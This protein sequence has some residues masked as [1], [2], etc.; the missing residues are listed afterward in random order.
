MFDDARSK[1]VVLV[2]HC[3]LNQNARSDGYAFFPGVM[4]EAA[5]VLSESGAG[6]LQMPCPELL[7]LGLKREQH[8]APEVGIRDALGTEEGQ[9]CCR[10]IARQLVHQ[11]TEYLRHGFEIVGVVGNDRS[12]ACGVDETSDHE[13]APRPGPGAFIEVLQAELA[14]AG[15]A[16]PF[17]AIRDAE[18]AESAAKMRALLGRR[19]GIP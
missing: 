4:G 3:L 15:L 12:P 7:C 9:A 14:A 17:I 18:W 5:R 8:H 19:G 1:R 11:V 16:L 2:V 6:V 13:G 10:K